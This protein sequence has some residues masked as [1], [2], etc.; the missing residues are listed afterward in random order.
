MPSGSARFSLSA[1]SGSITLSP[2]PVMIATGIMGDLKLENGEAITGV[3]PSALDLIVATYE[4]KIG[5]RNGARMAP[6]LWRALGATLSTARVYSATGPPPSPR[7]KN[8]AGTEPAQ[9]RTSRDN[10]IDD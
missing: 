4:T 7:L 10:P 3:D 9:P 2:S 1:C 6:A 8:G 5:P